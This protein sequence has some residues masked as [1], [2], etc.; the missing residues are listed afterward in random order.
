MGKIDDLHTLMRLLKEFDL[1]V[2]PI[3]EYAIKEKMEEC[4]EGNTQEIPISSVPAPID[5]EPRVN[6]RKSV[7]EAARKNRKRTIL[8]V[9]RTDGSVIEDSKATV[10]LGVTIKEIGVEKVRALNLSLDGMNLILVGENIL[11]PSQQYDLGEGYY[12]NTHSSTERKKYHHEKIFNALQP[13]WKVEIV[14]SQW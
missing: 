10:T 6:S 2:S 9:T 13:G 5:G 1:P 8:R 12:L 7:P 4:A 14:S 3:L 11:Y